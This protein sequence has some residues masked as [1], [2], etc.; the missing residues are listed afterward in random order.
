MEL[1][2][3]SRLFWETAARKM[4]L[5]RRRWLGSQ[6]S[7]NAEDMGPIFLNDHAVIQVP[8]D[9]EG[10]PDLPDGVLL[11]HPPFGS[12]ESSSDSDDSQWYGE[13]APGGQTRKRKGGKAGAPSPQRPRADPR[14][15]RG[16]GDA[17]FLEGHESPELAI[18]G[19]VLVTDRDLKH[20][21]LSPMT[22]RPRMA[23]SFR[24]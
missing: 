10:V 24:W 22:G 20:A 7:P 4:D 8:P 13:R 9:D 15:A 12:L 19:P 1:D 5:A 11:L 17:E 16:V 23:P 2:G 3:R 14:H 18:P 21:F 6:V